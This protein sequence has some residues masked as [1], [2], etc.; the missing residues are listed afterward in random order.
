MKV[1]EGRISSPFGP[2]KHPVTGVEATHHNGVDIATPTGTPVYTPV[3]GKV[4]LAASGPIGGLQIVIRADIITTYHFLH[5]S[6]ALVKAGDVV[7]KG[8]LIAKSGNTGRS[9]GPHLHFGIKCNGKYI[10][11]EPLINF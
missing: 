9:T 5:L 10:N 6:E 4:T 8:T 1:C 11:P 3:A 2:R 7:Y